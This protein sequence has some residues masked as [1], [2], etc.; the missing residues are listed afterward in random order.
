MNCSDEKVFYHFYCLLTLYLI[1]LI[2]FHIFHSWVTVCHSGWALMGSLSE[3]TVYLWDRP[4][5]LCLCHW[6]QAKTQKSHISSERPAFNW[7]N[8]SN[9]ASSFLSSLSRLKLSPAFLFF[10]CHL[11]YVF[12]YLFLYKYKQQLL[13]HCLIILSLAAFHMCHLC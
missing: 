11:F 12:K 2:F 10:F 1:H 9:W 6:Q 8:W 4:V 13:T 5:W 7:N 3:W